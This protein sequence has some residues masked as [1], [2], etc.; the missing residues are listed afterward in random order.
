MADAGLPPGTELAG[1]W[2]AASGFAAAAALDPA[3]AA[4]LYTMIDHLNTRHGVTVLMVLHDLQAARRAGK[5][6]HLDT[7]CAFFGPAADYYKSEAAHRLL[8]HQADA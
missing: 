8:G 5:I 1:D 6:L 3:A 4:E 7:G 2:S